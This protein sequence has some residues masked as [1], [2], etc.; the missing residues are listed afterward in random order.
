M[1]AVQVSFFVDPQGRAP[2]QLLREWHSLVDI[3]ACARAAGV[4][5]T[6]LQAHGRDEHLVREG[7]DFH[8]VSAKR[9]GV[10]LSEDAGFLRLLQE[11][12]PDVAHVHGLGFSQGVLGLRRCRPHLPILLQDHADRTPRWWRR[13]AWRR[14]VAAADG[15]S[16]CARGLAQPFIASHDIAPHVRIFEI[17]ESTSFFTPGDRTAARSITGLRGDP[18]ILWVAHLDANKDPLTVLDGVSTAILALPGLELWCCYGSAPLLGAVQE[19]VRTDAR[20][21]ERVHL[22]GRVPRERIELLMRAADLFVLGSHRE[23]SSFAT[24]EALATGLPPV[25]TE[26]PSLRALAGGAASYWQPGD[27]ASLTNALLLATENLQERR[28][29]TREQF[30]C[31]ISAAAVGSKLRAAYAALIEQRSHAAA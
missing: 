16:F 4:R 24:I 8:F 23:G 19:R 22:L 7:I 31:E 9:S 10:A 11:L 28:K 27:A 6:V 17:P 14:G 26:I 12:A 29:L 1:H 15:I 21:R 13:A 20:L 3:A 2:R 30:E 5:V 25:V 18:C